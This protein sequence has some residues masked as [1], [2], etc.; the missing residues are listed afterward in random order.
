MKIARG[1]QIGPQKV[2]LYGPEGIGKST[3]GAQFPAPLFLDVEQGTRHIDVARSQWTKLRKQ[4]AGPGKYGKWAL[5][6]IK[7]AAEDLFRR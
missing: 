5:F 6:A 7:C 4:G 3:F 1:V 2:V